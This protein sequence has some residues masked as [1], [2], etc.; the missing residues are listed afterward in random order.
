LSI[1]ELDSRVSQLFIWELILSKKF[2]EQDNQVLV[3]FNLD[4]L[5]TFDELIELHHGSLLSLDYY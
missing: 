3:L 2:D 1:D 5:E 4:Y